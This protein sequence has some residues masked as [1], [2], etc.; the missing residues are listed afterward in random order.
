[1]YFNDNKHLKNARYCVQLRIV[2]IP[3]LE[4]CLDINIWIES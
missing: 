2:T 3:I 4:V 1:M